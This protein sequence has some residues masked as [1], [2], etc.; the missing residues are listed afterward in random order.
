MTDLIIPKGNITKE[1]LNERAL[2]IISTALEGIT[3]PLEMIIELRAMEGL[4]KQ[5]LSSVEFKEAVLVE[6]DK[7]SK[8]DRE[9]RGVT[10]DAARSP[11]RYDYSQDEEW[12]EMN[13]EMHGLK[14]QLKAREE[15]LRMGHNHSLAETKTGEVL[16]VTKIEGAIVPKITIK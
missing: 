7:Y 6:I 16:Q 10:F 5:C 13:K 15:L 4:I 3:N 14:F 8:N 9:F 12:A 2:S 11:A 1:K